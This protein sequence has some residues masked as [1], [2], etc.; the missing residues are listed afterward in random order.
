MART[1]NSDIYGR[2]FGAT[3]IGAVWAKGRIIPGYDPNAL[4]ADITG[5]VMRL[6]DYGNTGSQYGWEVDHIKPAARGG[7]DDLANLQ[8][9]QWGVNRQKGDA[10]PWQPHGSM[11]RAL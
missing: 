1:P 10:Y 9:L 5:K 3:T 6:A 4:R 11:A 8:P 7:T 2:P